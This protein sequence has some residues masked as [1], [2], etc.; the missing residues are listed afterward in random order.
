MALNNTTYNKGKGGLGRPLPGKDFISGLILYVANG[1]L[2]SGFTTSKRIKQFFSVADAEAAGILDNYNDEVQAV[3]VYTLTGV[4][5]NG[6]PLAFDVTEP[7]GNVVHLGDILKG[8]AETT[9]TLLAAK[10]VAAINLLTPTTGYSAT[11]AAGAITINA[12]IGLGVFLNTG[13]PLVV[14]NP[15]TIAGSITTAFGGG[16]ASLQ[17]VWHYHISEY[18]RMQPKGQ[19]YT[20]FFAIPGSYTFTEIKTM[21]TFAKG[22]LRQI[23]IYKDGAALSASADTTAIQT[24]CLVLDGKKQGVSV[25]L[26]ANIAA[27]N[28]L[29]TLVDM[30]AFSNN[31]AS[32]IIGQDGAGLGNKLWYAYGKSITFLGAALG[33]V[34]LAKVNEDIAWVEKFNFSDGVELDTIAFAN[35]IKL[36]NID[37]D[38]LDGLLSAID[39]KRYIFLRDF[40]NTAGS[41]VNDSHTAIVQSSDYAYIE[42][43]RTIDKAIRSVDAKLTPLLAS[44]LELNTD[45]TLQDNDAV[46]FEN[47][48]EQGPIQMTKDGELSQQS[49][50][51]D[52]TQNV[53]TTSQVIV[54]IEMIPIGIARNIIV[55]IG[56]TAKLS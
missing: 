2:P 36:M 22:D 51:I 24:Q 20:G 38:S 42:N 31:K 27:V 50:T 45:G 56:Y 7:E 15:G 34:S 46:Y 30:S 9:V 25:L 39:L 6:D 10:M 33:A 26:G 54:T 37:P 47:Q 16:V 3:A 44:P 32:V 52:P 13:S 21:Q 43:N 53:A 18:F 41:Y 55:N 35:G 8:A 49:V 11:N 5:V 23:A 1:S 29:T 48:A 14:T 17:A 12:R 4:G 40:P 19:L 28:D